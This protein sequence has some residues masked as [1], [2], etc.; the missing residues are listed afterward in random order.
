M[1]LLL[2]LIGL[3]LV[4]VLMI[5]WF[6]LGVVTLVSS[7]FGLLRLCFVLLVICFAYDLCGLWVLFRCFYTLIVL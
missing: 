4:C 7:G 6:G 5:D 1:W 3:L 2:R